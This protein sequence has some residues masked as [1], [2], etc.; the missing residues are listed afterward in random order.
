PR[1]LID[2]DLPPQKAIT[3]LDIDFD[4]P[5]KTTYA[6]YDMSTLELIEYEQLPRF[7]AGHNGIVL[8]RDIEGEDLTPSE[9]AFCEQRL[10]AE[11][12][13]P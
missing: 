2:S 7:L 11:L 4:S 12:C 8:R 3:V 13:T 1:P 10:G 5:E 6:T 9:K